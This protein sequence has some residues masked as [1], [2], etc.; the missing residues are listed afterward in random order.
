M[1]RE[2]KWIL[3]IVAIGPIAVLVG[4]GTTFFGTKA[5]PA[6]VDPG[7]SL[8][9]R[10]QKEHPVTPAMVEAADELGK[11]PA[12]DF[13]LVDVEGRYHTLANLSEDKPL[14]LFF[15][16]K[17][18]PCCKGAKT[19][20]DRI[21]EVYGDEANVVGVI[22]ADPPMAKA[23][24]NAVL[25]T[26]PILCDPE[27]KTIQAYKAERGVY[28]TLVAPGGKVV[29]AYPGYSQSMLKEMGGL[30]ARLADVPP[31]EIVAKDAPEEMIS[32]C[33]FPGA[34]AP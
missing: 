9:F 1:T 5:N 24:S 2:A 6:P 27:M 15:V 19:F 25:P 22:N 13:G 20:M 34:I 29:K 14:V 11:K 32:G 23:W 16:E 31:R 26:F 8:V 4:L 3:G 33:A 12:P 10:E 28:T 7:A 18:C 17:E 30:I 21:Q